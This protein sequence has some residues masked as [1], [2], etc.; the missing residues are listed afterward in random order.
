VLL[1]QWVVWKNLV[2]V[3]PSPTVTGRQKPSPETV[4]AR[5]LQP[6]R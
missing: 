5:D 6:H 1:Y 4:T 3:E 2:T